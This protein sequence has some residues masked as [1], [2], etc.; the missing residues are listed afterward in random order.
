MPGHCNT[1][2]PRSREIATQLRSGDLSAEYQKCTEVE[3]K[4]GPRLWR[5]AQGPGELEVAIDCRRLRFDR[6]RVKVT[7]FLAQP[8]P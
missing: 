8:W 6:A 7:G 5:S 3:E 2:V 1:R 4:R